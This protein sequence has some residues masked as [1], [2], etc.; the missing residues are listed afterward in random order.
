MNRFVLSLVFLAILAGCEAPLVLN[1]VEKQTN[2]PLRRTDVF[3]AAAESRDSLV[4]VGSYGVILVSSDHGNTWTRVE[5]KRESDQQKPN[6]I[7]VATCP[8]QSFAALSIEGDVWLSADNG[9]SWQSRGIETQE[10]QQAI[11]CD[12][13][14]RIWVVGSF[15]SIL[16]STDKGKSWKSQSLND[17][18]ILTSV[19]FLDDKHGV[20]TGEFG[21]V[22]TTV[23]GGAEWKTMPV[24]QEEFIPLATFFR[25]EHEGWVVGLGG[26]IYYTEDGGQRWIKEANDIKAPLY[27]MGIVADAV[28]AVGESGV[29]LH[30]TGEGSGTGIQWRP[31]ELDFRSHTF[32]RVFLQTSDGSILLGGGA[33]LLRKT[34]AD[35]LEKTKKGAA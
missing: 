9:Q 30:R 26:V 13:T 35:E 22:L 3:Q 5:V 12:E 24:I 7:D 17:D 15:G 2:S 10:V 19:Q 14:G 21:T 1:G 23:D 34:K 29:I 8:D 28:F 31:A 6:L 4:A 25:N 11:T 16:S 20:I 27:G 18:K 32:I 33:G